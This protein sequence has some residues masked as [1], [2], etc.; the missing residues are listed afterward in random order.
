[1]E[2]KGDVVNGDE[3]YFISDPKEEH[4]S[5]IKTS[6]ELPNDVEYKPPP[7]GCELGKLK[8]KTTMQRDKHNSEFWTLLQ[9]DEAEMTRTDMLSHFCTN[10]MSF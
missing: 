4:I 10:H 3:G 5:D 9:H 2:K 6:S 1:M 8:E 7:V